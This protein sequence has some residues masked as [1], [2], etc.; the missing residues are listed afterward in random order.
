MS[1]LNPLATRRPLRQQ[2]HRCPNSL[3]RILKTRYV[4]SM[5][6]H[7]SHT[8]G[9]SSRS[10]LYGLVRLAASALALHCTHSFASLCFGLQ[11][12]V[13]LI[14]ENEENQI[15]SPERVGAF[16][17]RQAIPIA[18]TLLHTPSVIDICIAARRAE[19]AS[20]FR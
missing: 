3:V 12:P 8:Y 5:S 13:T 11:S 17:A 18:S 1:L 15:A 14:V 10:A 16:T 2:R 20:S 4:P 7:V 19:R 6:L 9:F